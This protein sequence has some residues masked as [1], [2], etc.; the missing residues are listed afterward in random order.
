MKRETYYRG[1]PGKKFGIWNDVAKKFQFGICEDTPMLA[2]ARL[3]KC[4]GDNARKWR[5][6]P[7]MLPDAEAARLTTKPRWFHMDMTVPNDNEKVLIMFSDGS[8]AVGFWK[9]D[10]QYLRSW[11]VCTG[12]GGYFTDCDTEPVQ[13]MPLPE[14]FAW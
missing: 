8:I 3:Y 2:E 12:E 6:Q 10:E 7:K 1:V 11:F 13:W 14:G 9:D 5:F 4:I